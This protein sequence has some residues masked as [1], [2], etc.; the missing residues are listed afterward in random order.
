MKNKY[1]NHKE[2]YK[3]FKAEQNTSKTT[4]RN[5]EF[6][7]FFMD[8][9]SSI[10]IVGVNANSHN[11]GG[12]GTEYNAP[13]Q[14]NC[15]ALLG[16]SSNDASLAMIIPGGNTIMLKNIEFM[17]VSK[18][19]T[20]KQINESIDELKSEIAQKEALLS[21]MKKYNL[22]SISEKDKKV[23]TA[24]SKIEKLTFT[25]S[26]EEKFSEVKEILEEI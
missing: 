26:D 15:S 9:V 20:V 16:S 4:N 19:Q 1:I 3:L 23:I 2:F 22:K 5:L 11:Y 21:L 12:V 7:Q 8:N 10:R 18:E 17:L 14:N 6:K 13:F 25:G 24:L